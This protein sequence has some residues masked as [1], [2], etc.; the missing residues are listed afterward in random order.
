MIL[1]DRPVSLAPFTVI[2]ENTN[3]SIYQ[4]TA[5]NEATPSIT[6]DGGTWSGI[7]GTGDEAWNQ[8]QDWSNA[9]WTLASGISIQPNYPTSNMFDG[10]L[11]TLT[12]FVLGG[13]GVNTLPLS[14]TNVTKLEVYAE[15]GSDPASNASIGYNNSNFVPNPLVFI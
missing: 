12:S 11:S 14:I 9:S 2:S 13:A 4:V 3:S 10:D 6:T 8:S 1:L 15:L 7:D 5:I